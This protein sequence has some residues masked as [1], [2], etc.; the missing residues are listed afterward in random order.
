MVLS[1][2][3]IL[4]DGDTTRLSVFSLTNTSNTYLEQNKKNPP[5]VQMLGISHGTR[6]GC[7]N[8][9]Y[10]ALEDDQMSRVLEC[11]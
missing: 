9:G 8:V 4:R 2:R 10:R 7:R 11:D 6:A 5:I 3:A 1:K